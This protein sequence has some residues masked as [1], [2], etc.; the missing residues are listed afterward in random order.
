MSPVRP[1]PDAVSLA[2]AWT[3]HADRE[4]AHLARV[5]DVL[6]T[7]IAALRAG[8]WRDAAALADQHELVGESQDLRQARADILQRG[9]ALGTAPG[10]FTLREL[11]QAVPEELRHELLRRRA[12]L[13][14][15]ALEVKEAAA[16]CAFLARHHLD[17]L[18]RF[19]LELAGSPADACRYG[20]AG[21]LRPPTCG[22]LIQAQG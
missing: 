8:R 11:A 20:P 1:L 19:L 4:Q 3:Q 17:F 14:E 10:E 18:Q 2:H 16:T 22:A 21:Q 5:L 6:R 12:R 9:A 13:R 7:T 15:A